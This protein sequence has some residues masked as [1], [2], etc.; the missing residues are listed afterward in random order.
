MQG[1]E[2]FKGEICGLKDEDGV[3]IEGLT[4]PYA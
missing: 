4:D 1:Y 2:Q 3:V